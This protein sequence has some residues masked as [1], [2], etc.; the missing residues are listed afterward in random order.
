MFELSGTTGAS[1]TIEMKLVYRV[2]VA[3]HIIIIL[4]LF[5]VNNRL[6]L[7]VRCN[8]FHHAAVLEPIFTEDNSP[9][10]P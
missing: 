8:V 9:F 1:G 6:F 7:T 10:E 4:M 5:Q 3:I 2:G